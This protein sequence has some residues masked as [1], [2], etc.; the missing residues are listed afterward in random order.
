M[1]PLE[2]FAIVCTGVGPEMICRFNFACYGE[3]CVAPDVCR[4]KEEELTDED[5]ARIAALSEF[6]P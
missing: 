3:I 5:R 4:K 2:A 1:K 6:A